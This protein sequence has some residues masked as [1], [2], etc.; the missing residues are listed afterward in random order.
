MDTAWLRAEYVEKGRSTYQIASDVGCNHK[1][2]YYHLR[3][4]G[5]RT[6]PRGENLK[7]RDNYMSAFLAVGHTG[8]RIPETAQKAESA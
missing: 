6:R 2:I 3:R 1:T 5:I 8:R 7:G 4:S